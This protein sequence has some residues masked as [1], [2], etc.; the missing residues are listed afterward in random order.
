M[1]HTTS[2]LAATHSDVDGLTA[3][4]VIGTTNSS[5]GLQVSEASNMPSEPAENY[6][7]VNYQSYIIAQS[8]DQDVLG[9]IK[10]GFTNFVETG[11]VWALLVGL[12]VGFVIRG[13]T[14]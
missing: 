11:Q 3:E 9:D 14:R 5:S 1:S 12:I 4:Q 13:L 10:S 2:Y 6:Q 8:F 7:A